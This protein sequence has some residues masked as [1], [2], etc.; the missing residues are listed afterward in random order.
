M[1]NDLRFVEAIYD[2]LRSD[3]LDV[4]LAGG[5]A[6][7]L[8]GMIQPRPHHDVDFL[9]RAESFDDVDEFIGQGEVAE[10]EAK[11]FHHKRAFE[12]EKTMVELILV[13]PELTT[14][15][16]GR[17]TYSWPVDTFGD[18][19]RRPRLVSMA[20]LRHYR[21]NRPPAHPAGASPVAP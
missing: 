4:W 16:W 7:E 3:G 19:S 2:Q 20:A 12:A 15:F 11:R 1:P 14:S 8:Y 9:Y 5:W 17:H 10:I 18:N 13:S 21:H 6:E